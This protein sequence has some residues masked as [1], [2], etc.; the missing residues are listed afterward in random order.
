MLIGFISFS[1]LAHLILKRMH[2]NIYCIHVTQSHLRCNDAMQLHKKN[3]LVSMYGHTHLGA[4]P[5]QSPT[6]KAPLLLLVTCG[7][8]RSPLQTPPA[9]VTTLIKEM[10]GDL[11]LAALFAGV[12]SL[13]W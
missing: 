3:V 13:G 5:L 2:E 4:H 7:H 12:R 6:N 9:Q 1:D 11:P 10:N 8:L